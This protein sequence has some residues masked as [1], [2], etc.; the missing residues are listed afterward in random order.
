M[1]ERWYTDFLIERIGA[2]IDEMG[3][4]GTPEGKWQDPARWEMQKIREERA[5]NA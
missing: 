3:T 1:T 2:I 5:K 4:P